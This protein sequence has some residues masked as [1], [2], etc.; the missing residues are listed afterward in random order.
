MESLLVIVK[1][2]ASRN[3]HA[4][5]VLEQQFV[6]LGHRHV[7]CFPQNFVTWLPYVLLFAKLGESNKL[8]RCRKWGLRLSA[9]LALQFAQSRS[10]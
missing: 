9:T 10:M 7:Y 3:K 5:D 8:A 4:L 2:M 6:W 1:D